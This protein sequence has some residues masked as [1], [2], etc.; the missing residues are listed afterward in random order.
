MSKSVGVAIQP[1]SHREQLLLLLYKV[2]LADQGLGLGQG[3]LACAG[4]M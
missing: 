1:F 3:L 2:G 4:C